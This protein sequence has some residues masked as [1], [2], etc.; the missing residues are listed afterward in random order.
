MPRLTAS[1]IAAAHL[2][3]TTSAYAH[4]EGALIAPAAWGG[5]IVGAAFGGWFGYRRSHPGVG[6]GWS[7]GALFL[8]L[9]VWAGWQGEWLAG[10]LLYLLIVPFAGVIPLTVAFF[11]IHAVAGFIRSRLDPEVATNG[12]PTDEH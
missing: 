2:V 5:L 12:P 4:G 3:V 6:L 9:V 1:L 8:G 11:V 7:I 10:A